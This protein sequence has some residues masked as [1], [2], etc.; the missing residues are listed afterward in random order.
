M[1][2]PALVLFTLLAVLFFFPL[3]T[4]VA[5]SSNEL[6]AQ[7]QWMNSWSSWMGAMGRANYQAE[8][9]KAQAQLVTAQAAMVSAAANANKTNCE[10]LQALEQARSLALDNNQKKAE[11]FWAKRTLH[12][13]QKILEPRTRPSSEDLERYNKAAAPKRLTEEQFDRLRGEIDWPLV[14]KR[15]QFSEQRSQIEKLFLRHLD[16]PQE[17]IQGS[18][19]EIT[20]EINSELVLLLQAKETSQTEHAKASNFIRSLAYESQFEFQLPSQNGS[21]A[22]R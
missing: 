16:Y 5:Q 20:E 6:N 18:I 9:L 14:L 1:K 19:R 8:M 3:Q 22:I 17:D 7:S 4:S 21:L 2:N 15:D 11:V 13:S 12:K 10:A